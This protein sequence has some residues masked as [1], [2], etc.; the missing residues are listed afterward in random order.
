MLI[1]EQGQSSS[2]YAC[3]RSHA[4]IEGIIQGPVL[5]KARHILASISIH[6]NKSARYDDVILTLHG[7]GIHRPIQV[8]GY[9]KAVIRGTVRVQTSQIVR[10]GVITGN[11]CS[12]Q[13]HPP[14]L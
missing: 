10:R 9:V 3:R 1:G 2:A 6:V 7:N 4:G 13:D 14:V 11:E 12:P 8:E 5:A